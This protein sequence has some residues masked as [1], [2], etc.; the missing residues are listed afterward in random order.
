VPLY[1]GFDSSTQGLTATA[2]EVTDRARRVL[3]TR[4]LNYD[5]ELPHYHTSHGVL[6]SN[7]PGVVHAP[8]AMWTE[9]LDRLMHDITTRESVDWR[10][11]RAISG[12]AQQHGS[13]YLNA[14]AS[15]RL[16]SLDPTRPLIEQLTSVFNR[17]TSPVWMDSSTTAECREIEQALGGADIVAQQTGSRAFERFTGPQIRKFWKHDGAGFA[18]TARIHLVSSWMASVLS[19]GDAPVD[20]ADASGMNLMRLAS[21]AWWPEALD[22]TAPGLSKRLPTLTSSSTMAG[23]LSNYWMQRYNLPRARVVVWSGD[24]PCSLVGT[25]AVREGMVTISLGTS[26]TIFGPM[27]QPRVSR[28]GAGHVFASPT[29]GFMG[30]TVFQNGSLARERVRERYGLDWN[31][32]SA[33]LGATPPGNRGALLLPWFGPEITPVVHAG[34]RYARDLDEADGPSS[35]RAIVEG[36]IMA[37]ALHSRWMGVT[38]QIIHATGGGS[39]NDAI[40]Q[41]MADVFDAVVHRLPSSNSAALGAALRAFHADRIADGEPIAWEEVCA[42]F[43]AATPAASPVRENVE[44]Y[45]NVIEQYRELESISLS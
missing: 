20:A 25:G 5:R 44:T 3:F 9:A 24:N 39:N 13:V 41:V 23:W 26:D 29:G 17:A 14:D 42:G 7:A 15:S 36:Q 16:T 2:L 34:G 10:D 33:A 28:D 37:L 19:G 8:P 35:V 38:P 21:S 11:L 22:A 40:L 30:M 31:G 4:T 27:S 6:P 45:K 32:F 1:L 43:T 18:A 12:S